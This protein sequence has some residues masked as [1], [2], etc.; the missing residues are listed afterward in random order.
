MVLLSFLDGTTNSKYAKALIPV[1]EEMRQYVELITDVQLGEIDM[2][3]YKLVKG[4]ENQIHQRFNYNGRI[5]SGIDS[6][7]FT[8]ILNNEH[9]K[10]SH[11]NNGGYKINYGRKVLVLTD[12]KIFERYS[13]VSF[14]PDAAT[15]IFDKK[16]SFDGNE[17]TIPVRYI[18]FSTNGVDDMNFFKH[19][20]L[21]E[22]GH[23]FGAAKEGRSN[24]FESQGSHCSNL[25]VMNQSLTYNDTLRLYTQLARK[26][27]QFC[28]QC[29]EELRNF[30]D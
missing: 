17:F 22:L 30:R 8:E 28:P 10:I 11:D 29:Q 25:C 14:F 27:R 4:I 13:N 2:Q 7:V 16:E 23:M 1:I 6:R 21:H 24:T 20:A 26:G 5:Y 9:N 18:I 19:V 12:E 15:Y 3:G